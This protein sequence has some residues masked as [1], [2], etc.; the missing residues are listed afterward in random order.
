MCRLLQER[1]VDLPESAEY[2]EDLK[3]KK[4]TKA[5]KNISLLTQ[6]GV[7]LIMPILLCIGGCVLL[8]DH[9]GIGT[10]IFIPGILL[11]IGG[12]CSTAWR[13]YGMIMKNEE[14]NDRGKGTSF[15]R[16]Y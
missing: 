16:H 1:P 5:L 12:S 11:G 10:W 4:W 6:L 2:R 15:N 9:T 7:S 8:T 13:F 3:L 14:K